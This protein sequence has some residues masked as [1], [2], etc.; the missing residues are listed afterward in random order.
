MSVSGGNK[1]EVERG[2]GGDDEKML[3]SWALGCRVGGMISFPVER[4]KSWILLDSAA[5][6]I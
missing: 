4:E 5:I 6:C 1:R 3:R 2:G